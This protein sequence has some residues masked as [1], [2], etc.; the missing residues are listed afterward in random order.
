M[1]TVK[2]HTNC[3]TLFNQDFRNGCLKENLSSLSLDRIGEVIR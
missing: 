2:L 3:P 1:V